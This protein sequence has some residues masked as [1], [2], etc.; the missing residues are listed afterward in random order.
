MQ[1]RFSLAAMTRNLQEHILNV[2]SELFYS[3]GIKTTGVDAVV[4]AAG[5]TKM[6]LY[7][8]YPSKDDLVLAHLRKSRAKLQ[9]YIQEYLFKAGTD[10]GRQLLAVFDAFGDLQANPAFRG[11]P[12]INAAAEFADSGS[13]I[14]QTAAE[15]SEGFRALLS[16]LA[17]RAGVR[18][19][20]PLSK[21][22]AM[23]IAGAMVGEQMR[24]GTENMRLAREAAK[25]LIASARD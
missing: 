14:Q 20:E 7:K 12:F 18:D 19:P 11:C 21:Q 2:A 8:Y 15:F 16:D 23:L 6:S 3:Q 10:P 13:P 25:I 5:T 9:A 1:H 17:A 24:R 4:K 22:L